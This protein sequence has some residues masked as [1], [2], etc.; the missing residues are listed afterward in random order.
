M[1]QETHHHH[2]HHSHEHTASE[3]KDPRFYIRIAILCIFAL[4]V[5]VYIPYIAHKFLPFIRSV[6]YYHKF[7][8]SSICYILL[9][10]CLMTLPIILALPG[11]L[12]SEYMDKPKLIGKCLG[13]ISFFYFTGMI[14]DI[15]TYN[16]IG[17]YVD[18]GSDP[19]MLKLLWNSADTVGITFCGVQGA[20]YLILS[21][22]LRGHKKN[23]VIMFFITFAASILMP[24][25][26]GWLNHTMFTST[27]YVW[28]YKNIYFYISQAVTLIGLLLSASSRYLWSSAFW[29]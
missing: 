16:V 18:D 22:M 24:L 27:W 5:L 8:V 2:H 6:S 28:F 10:I 21:K 3:K 4:A 19:I 26:Y 11:L 17:G 23:I 7:N 9:R 20:L 13:L 29:H 15:V 25:A 1:E 12:Y 14:A